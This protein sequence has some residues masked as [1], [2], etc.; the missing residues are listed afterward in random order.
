MFAI[1]PTFLYRISWVRTFIRYDSVVFWGPNLLHN[2][3]I[4]FGTS[5]EVPNFVCFC[6]NIL[7]LSLSLLPPPWGAA[8]GF[9][10]K[11]NLLEI[12]SPRN[13]EHSVTA[14]NDEKLIENLSFPRFWKKLTQRKRKENR[15]R[16]QRNAVRCS[17]PVRCRS[18]QLY[19][20]NVFYHTLGAYLIFFLFLFWVGRRKTQS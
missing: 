13:G 5:G 20:A 18:P 15:E 8:T 12:S 16:T 17:E 4:Y 11:R 10:L 14:W 3:G 2:T 19:S 1:P 6:A 9:I 7:W